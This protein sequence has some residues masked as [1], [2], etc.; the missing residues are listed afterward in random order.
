MDFLTL[1]YRTH[2]LKTPHDLQEA[3][4]ALQKEIFLAVDTEFIRRTTY[5]P[6]FALL[7]LATATDSYVIDPLELTDLSPLKPLLSNPN[8]PK[9][10]HSSRQDIEIFRHILH[11]IPTPLVDTQILAEFCGFE[12]NISLQSLCHTFFDVTLSKSFQKLNWLKR[13]LPAKALT[14]AL[15]DAEYVYQCHTKLKEQAGPKYAWFQE[16]MQALTTSEFYEETPTKLLSKFKK[17]TRSLKTTQRETLARILSVRDT[18]ARQ[19]NCLT[20]DVLSDDICYEL[21]KDESSNVQERLEKILLN[22]NVSP[23]GQNGGQN[24]Q[25]TLSNEQKTTQN[26]QKNALK[27]TLNEAFSAP[28]SLENISKNNRVNKE[29][30]ASLQQTIHT[31]AKQHNLNPN[32]LARSRDIKHLLTNQPSRLTQGWRGDLLKNVL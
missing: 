5:H 6:R 13:P 21:C 12:E 18:L 8:I 16:D 26:M 19:I 20:K 11:M 4:Q 15:E 32:L 27:N 30:A 31:I 17:N 10:L 22:E 28:I 9:V 23:N 25:K 3:I 7:Q 24:P 1:N 2:F 14:Y 29:S